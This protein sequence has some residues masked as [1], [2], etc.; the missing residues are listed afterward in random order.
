MDLLINILCKIKKQFAGVNA[1]FGVMEC[2][3]VE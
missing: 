3:V 1:S 2:G